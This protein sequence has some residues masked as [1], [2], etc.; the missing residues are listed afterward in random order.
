MVPNVLVGRH[1]RISLELVSKLLYR[2]FVT[3]I[4]G[5][6]GLSRLVRSLLLLFGLAKYLFDEPGAK[7]G[8][9]LH[10]KRHDVAED[11]K[12]LI[13]GG[14]GVV[15]VNSCYIYSIERSGS[16]IHPT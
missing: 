6:G 16:S 8:E 13:P 3:P 4:L 9:R 7:C 11:L 2:R 10:D 1:P 12:A 5:G 15:M 14:G